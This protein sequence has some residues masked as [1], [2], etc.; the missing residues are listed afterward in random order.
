MKRGGPLRADPAK[1]AA[2]RQ[3]SKKIKPVSDK[4]REGSPARR[5]VVAKALDGVM[6]G[7]VLSESAE[8]GPCYGPSTPHRM[9]KGSAG[10]DRR[11]A[12]YVDGNVV[13]TCSFHNG[14]IEDHPDEATEL[15]MVIRD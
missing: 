15:G 12:G 3:R 7:C 9:R 5:A 6:S 2:W 11:T 14:W 13:A 1:A 4:R 10:W 8:A